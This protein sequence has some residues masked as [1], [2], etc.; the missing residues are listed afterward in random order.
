MN[1][2]FCHWRRPQATGGGSRTR[3]GRRFA[4]IIFALASVAISQA[5]S[6]AGE[7]GI[8][9]PA[10]FAPGTGGT[11]GYI[12]G[13]TQMAASAGKVQIT[14]IFNPDGGPGPSADPGYA[15]EMSKLSLAGGEILGYVNTDYGSVPIGAVEA[16]IATYLTQYPGLINGFFLDGMSNVITNIGYYDA[17]YGFIKSESLSYQAIGNPGTVTNQSYADD[18]AADT[19]LTFEGNAATYSVATV[20]S[21]V[22][23]YP[24]STFANTVYAESAVQGMMRDLTLA[25]DRNVGYIYV[26]DEAI[27][28]PGGYL[29]DRLPSYWNEEVA[30]VAA[31]VQE[32]SSAILLASGLLASALAT[33]VGRSV[34]GSQPKP[35][36]R[37]CG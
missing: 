16:E 21:W 34:A 30:A 1:G 11:E 28:P 5:S 2:E 32:P 12:D 25:A 17:L 6:R 23:A 36:A 37:I 20:P 27:N 8:L 14:A 31:A 15:A 9:V 10:Y 19:L 13:W 35:P 26:T 24:I 18:P 7:I 4:A 33:R 3:L 29:Y 22:Y